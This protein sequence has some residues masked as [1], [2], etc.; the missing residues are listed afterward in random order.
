MY[1]LI[2]ASVILLCC[3]LNLLEILIIGTGC[4][5][6]LVMEKEEIHPFLFIIVEN[7]FIV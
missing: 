3:N 5:I 6:L 2:D 1:S 7:S 4:M